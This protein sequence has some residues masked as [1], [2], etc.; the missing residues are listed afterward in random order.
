MHGHISSGH[1]ACQL[2]EE[3]WRH[4]IHIDDHHVCCHVY[5]IRNLLLPQVTIF[6]APEFIAHNSKN[7]DFYK[8][9]WISNPFEL[10]WFKGWATMI[11]SYNCQITLFYVR[12]ELMHKTEAR[13]R[14]ISRI[15]ICIL[16]AFYTL[17]CFSGYF[18]LGQNGIPKMITLRKPLGMI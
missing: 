11:L 8:I 2:C 10:K 16:F 18:S 15:F 14:K 1:T 7:E 17:I 6:Q 5:D 13:T 12:G 3:S 9:V 4:A